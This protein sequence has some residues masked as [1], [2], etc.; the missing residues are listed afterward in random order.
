GDALLAVARLL[1]HRP[2][3][4]LGQAVGRRR[5][6]GRHGRIRL[7]A[8]RAV[9]VEREGRRRL[10]GGA[11]VGAG[12]GGHRGPDAELPDAARAVARRRHDDDLDLRRRVPLARVERVVPAALEVGA[13][14]EVQ[15]VAQRLGDAVHDAA[16]DLGLDAER[17]DGQ[18]DVDDVDDLGDARSGVAV[19]SAAT[20]GLRT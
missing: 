15:A 20:D 13:V 5:R 11:T 4:R 9:V 18:A 12:H 6:D 7:E 14:L 1:A 16:H 2:G 17:I 8:E 10:A 3:L 19:A